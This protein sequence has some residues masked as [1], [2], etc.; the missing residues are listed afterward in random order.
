MW[1][2]HTIKYYSALK[3]IL[4]HITRGMNPE[5]IM[6]SKISHNKR[7]HTTG[8]LLS[9]VPR[10]IKHIKTEDRMVVAEGTYGN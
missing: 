6:Q 7:T 2:I 10:V 5:V 8:F 4:T 3:K 9:E 1:Y